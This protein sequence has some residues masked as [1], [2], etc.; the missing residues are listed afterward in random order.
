MQRDTTRESSQGW[1]AFDCESD[2]GVYNLS[3]ETPTQNMEIWDYPCSMSTCNGNALVCDPYARCCGRRGAARPLPIPIVQ[4]GEH[5]MSDYNYDVALSFAGED[6]PYVHAVAQTLRSNEV[7]VFYDDFEKVELWGK[8]LGE[9]LDQVYRLQSRYC[10]IFVSAAY[11]SKV[12]TNH[13]R[14]SAL[15]RAIQER[16]EYILPARFDETELPGM[17]PTVA[18]IPLDGVPPEQFATMI[19]EKMGK[20]SG[21]A[22]VR[23]EPSF[24]VPRLKTGNFN[25]Y[26]AAFAM[27]SQVR[28]ELESRCNSIAHLG[29]SLSAFGQ[30]REHSIRIVANGKT[31]YSLDMRLDETFGDAAITFHGTHGVA[32]SGGNA[33]NAWG[34]MEQNPENQSSVLRFNDMSLLETFG[35]E[36]ILAPEQFIDALWGKICDEIEREGGGR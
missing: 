19:L 3:A 23:T 16:S 6:R 27:M 35:G 24:R 18:Y 4:E 30:D 12:W 22:A 7:S 10:V 31:V 36:T 9:F 21:G 32:V 5:D 11:A 34:K 20:T 26:S 1:L 15:S 25:P 13:E 28:N 33:F 8:D 17:R 14:K 29:V 2:L